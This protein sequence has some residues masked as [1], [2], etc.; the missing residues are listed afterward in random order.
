MSKQSEMTKFLTRLPSD[1][2]AEIK[3]AA[4]ANNRSMN[5]EMI[6]RL[7]QPA[8][9][10]VTHLTLKINSKDA[11]ESLERM[12]TDMKSKCVGGQTLVQGV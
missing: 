4:T 12:L 9:A 11:A 7:S 1:L 2:H 5:G 3:A 10:N 6:H 8:G